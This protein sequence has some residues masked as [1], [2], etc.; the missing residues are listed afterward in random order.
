[1]LKKLHILQK[2]KLRNLCLHKKKP[3]VVVRKNLDEGIAFREELILITEKVA[4]DT[5]NFQESIT[6]SGM[7]ILINF[8]FKIKSGKFCSL[9]C[10]ILLYKYFSLISSINYLSV[11]LQTRGWKELVPPWHVP[12]VFLV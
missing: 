12:K 10:S 5:R 6:G 8:I 9:L 2:R 7:L 1:M 4:L 3:V 11:L